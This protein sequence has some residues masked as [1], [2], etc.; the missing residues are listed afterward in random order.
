MPSAKDIKGALLQ[1]RE[2]PTLSEEGAISSGSTMLN[3]ACTD[4]P[5]FAFM[6]GGYYYLIGDSSSGKTWLSMTCFAE[7]CMSKG[8]KDHRLIF[9][10]VE[11]GALMDVEHY[12]GKAVAKRREIFNSDTIEDFYFGITDLIAEGK[13]FI[14]VLDSQDALGSAGSQKKFEEH[15]KAARE[16]K[17][18][19]GSYGD[20]K[21]KIHSE[22]IRNVLAG[23][24]AT[25]SILIII[26][27]TR[28]NLGFGFAEKT[29]SGGKALKFYANIEIWT[30]VG[31]KL[32][33]TVR[34]QKRTI[35]AKCLAQIKKNRVT[36]KVGKDREV[37][38]PIYYD[39]GIDDLGS[40]VDYLTIEKHWKVKKQT[41]EAPEI[42]FEGTR[43]KL[44]SYIEDENL[45]DKV[46]GIV[47]KL[48]N[49]IEEASKP[50]GRK[51]RYE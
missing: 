20:G 46:R 4:D 43:P 12:F 47:G 23:L 13:P 25:G 35:G 38:I 40:M 29:R 28:D 17:V 16:G 26:G 9:D 8:F 2:R 51:K 30:A 19:D 5:R 48:W 41:I 27:Q 34:E 22:N 10:D 42:M 15:K 39:L 37:E 3:L 36:G 49:E 50:I 7:A 24:R 11:G 44:L 33:K 31:G 21:A 45:E 1:K 6:K 18:A 32:T 14:Y